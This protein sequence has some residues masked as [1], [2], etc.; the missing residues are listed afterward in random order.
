MDHAEF[1]NIPHMGK[2]SNFHLLQTLHPKSNIAQFLFDW[3]L[4]EYRL[5]L[6]INLNVYCV[7]NITIILFQAFIPTTLK[8]NN[9][10]KIFY[11]TIFVFA[12]QQFASSLIS[13]HSIYF[14]QEHH[15]DE[16]NHRILLKNTIA[17]L[18][19]VNSPCVVD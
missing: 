11:K 5:K 16:H 2:F 12:R 19:M 10:P 15:I 7:S 13:R 18:Q 14:I 17:N 1:T 8:N 6:C 4:F 9:S 3:F